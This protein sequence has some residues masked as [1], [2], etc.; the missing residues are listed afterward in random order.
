MVG[1]SIFKNIHVNDLKKNTAIRSF[2]GATI[3]TLQDKLQQFNIDKCETVI[4]RV[5]GNDADQGMDLNNF[6]DSYTSFINDLTSENRHIIVSGL[7]SRANANLDPYNE[8]LRTLYEDLNIDFVD[9]YNSF[10]LASGDLA[11]SVFNRDG[12][13]PN[14]FGI[15]QILKNIDFYHRVAAPGTSFK[16][17]GSVRRRNS[18]QAQS[19]NS[20]K[21][22]NFH[23]RSN[24]CH[25]CCRKGH[26][27]I[28]CWYNNRN[29]HFNG[30]ISQ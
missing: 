26:N 21:R 17:Y 4:I 19:F 12:V 22:T 13:H 16:P 29:T 30:Y 3:K 27:I 28:D 24:N 25:M 5:G 2:P 6:T 20:S 14:S 23:N 7:L 9:S 18:Y 1:S 11:D 15:K 10:L 8:R